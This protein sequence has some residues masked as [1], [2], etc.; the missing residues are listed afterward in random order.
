LYPVNPD[1]YY[2]TQLELGQSILSAEMDAEFYGALSRGE[3]PNY[4]SASINKAK[5]NLAK[6]TEMLDNWN[7]W[8]KNTGYTWKGPVSDRE[9]DKQ[10]ALEKELKDKELDKQIDQLEKDKAQNE[11]DAEAA[12]TEARNLIAQ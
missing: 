5:A 6:A 9:Y 2:T 1:R 10:K 12:A 8:K 3:S 4:N 11:A 7:R